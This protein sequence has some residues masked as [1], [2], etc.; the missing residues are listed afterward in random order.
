MTGIR[1]PTRLDFLDRGKSLLDLKVSLNVPK[2]PQQI[3]KGFHYHQSTLFLAITYPAFPQIEVYFFIHD[4]HLYSTWQSI[5]YG[6]ALTDLTT[7]WLIKEIRLKPLEFCHPD[8]EYV[9][10]ISIHK[11]NKFF[12]FHKTHIGIFSSSNKFGANTPSCQRIGWISWTFCS[13]L[14]K[15]D[16][17]YRRCPRPILNQLATYPSAREITWRNDLAKFGAVIRY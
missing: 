2:W 6:M 16:S 5:R 15:M 14:T 1:T 13:K 8:G 4:T 7:F 17:V 10:F 11:Y 3:M 12:V 9:E